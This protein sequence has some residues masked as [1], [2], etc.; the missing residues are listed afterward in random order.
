VLM[1]PF[2]KHIAARSDES[3]LLPSMMIL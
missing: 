3:S 2:E 1:M